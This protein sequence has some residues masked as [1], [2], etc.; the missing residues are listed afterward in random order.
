VI[1][2]LLNNK[3]PGRATTAAMGQYST[4]NRYYVRA[5]F[6]KGAFI[7]CKFNPDGEEVRA[8]ATEAGVLGKELT[9]ILLVN[10]VDKISDNIILVVE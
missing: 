6:E 3:L 2:S 8:A 9:G 1:A 4:Q 7:N 10:L 5:K